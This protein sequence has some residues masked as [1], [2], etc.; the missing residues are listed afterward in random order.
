MGYY[1]LEDIT[2]VPTFRRNVL[3]HI[4]RVAT[5][6][7]FAVVGYKAF[8]PF[9]FC[10]TAWPKKIVA[11]HS[12]SSLSYDRS[13]ASSK[14]SSPNSTIQCSRNSQ[15]TC[16]IT[17]TISPTNWHT[18]F[19]RVVNILPWKHCNFRP[20]KNPVATLYVTGL[21]IHKTIPIVQPT[22]RT[23]YL[24]LFIFVK[25]STCFGRSFRPSSGVENCV[26]SNGICQT[27]AATC[28]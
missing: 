28:C 26:Y 13:K 15:Q 3:L 21:N 16:F 9:P 1:V 7:Q 23:P 4:F 27:A 19:S 20:L 8:S 14:A 6:F 18:S 5:N 2:F 12:F 17:T 24:K 11:F 22:R 25:R 10:L